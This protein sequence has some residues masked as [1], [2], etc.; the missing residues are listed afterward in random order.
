MV[1]ESLDVV[2]YLRF[3]EI[4]KYN[5]VKTKNMKQKESIE[6]ETVGEMTYSI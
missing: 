5:A 6:V 3:M 1:I 2:K 4:H